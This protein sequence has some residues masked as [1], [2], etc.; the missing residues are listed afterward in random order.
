[1]AAEGR[2]GALLLTSFAGLLVVLLR[3]SSAP[4]LQPQ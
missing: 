3:G 1:M 4:R 2:R